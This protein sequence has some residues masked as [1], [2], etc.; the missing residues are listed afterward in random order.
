MP[1]YEYACDG[2]HRF[3]RRQGF[4]ATP[5]D[6][7]PTCEAPS[8]RVIHAP[9]VHYKGSGFYTT[10]YARSGSYQADSKGESGDAKSDSGDSG[11]DKDAAESKKDTSDSKAPAATATKDA[12]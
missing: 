1:I 10:D 5:I 4:D 8:A 3:E 6:V 12:D 2:G 11:G 9:T 7:C